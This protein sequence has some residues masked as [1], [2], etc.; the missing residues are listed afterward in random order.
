ME[1]SAVRGST[2][3][4]K[5]NGTM[6]VYVTA[7]YVAIILSSIESVRNGAG[8]Q[9]ENISIMLG[10]IAGLYYPVTSISRAGQHWL[11]VLE[12]IQRLEV[13]TR[14]DG[15]RARQKAS[16]SK[17]NNNHDDVN[18]DDV[19]CGP[20]NNNTTGASVSS[21]AAATAPLFSE[22]LQLK[23]IEFQYPGASNLTLKGLDA[24]FGVGTYTCIVGES[25]CGKST[26]LNIITRELIETGGD[27]LIDGEKSSSRFSVESYRKHLG[28]VLQD[29]AFFDGSIRD[30][31]L[32]GKVD[33]SDDEVEEAIGRAQ[34]QQFVSQLP[35]GMHT[36]L[37]GDNV[38]L[39][40]GQ[41]QRIS[42]AR[43]LVRKPTLLILDE[44]TSALDPA[45]EKEVI[46][47]IKRLSVHDKIAT[48]SVTHRLDTTDASDEIFV[49][50]D[51]VVYEKGTPDM[52]NAQGTL[53]SEIRGTQCAKD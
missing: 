33:A 45:T 32:I 12:A 15:G 28:V 22:S 11:N 6:N 9:V 18:P 40:G 36:Q 19:E 35:D 16:P 14:F 3:V 20:R 39:S 43:A 52:L 53:F 42:L 8:S 50:K 17:G 46:K 47:T 21:S 25:G 49:L 5:V 31:I 41:A 34:C 23:G 4:A 29:N 27:V 13:F 30:N 51:G 48:I 2:L 10:V 1:K 24:R 37:G 26:M 44:A 7:L 38:N